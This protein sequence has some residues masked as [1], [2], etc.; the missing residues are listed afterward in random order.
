VRR[1]SIRAS[2][3]SARP[4]VHSPYRCRECGERF[5]VMSRRVYWF[6]GLLGFAVVAGA[7][8]W[9]I[10]GSPA[11]HRPLPKSNEA[12]E[13]SSYDAKLAISNDPAAEY[14]IAH[15][16]MSGSGASPDKKRALAWLELAASHGNID[17]QFEYGNALREGFGVLQD[18]E[19]A[20]KWLQMAAER[21]NADAQYALGQMYR[22]GMGVPADNEKAYMWF[23]LAAAQELSGASVQRDAVLRLLTPAQ[24]LDAQAEARRLSDATDKQTAVAQ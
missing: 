18:Y 1:S 6:V 22:A 17:A 14:R 11:D 10:V 5:Y 8:A 2:E 15:M 13:S 4:R 23:N 7:V 24:V 3:A 20:A 9:N 19:R 21:G 16:Y 12:T